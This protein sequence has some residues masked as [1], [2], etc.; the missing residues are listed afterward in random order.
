M[1]TDKLKIIIKE[2]AD[3]TIENKIIWQETSAER[4]YQTLL[5]SGSITIEKVS[6]TISDHIYFSISNVKGRQIENINLSFADEAYDLLEN[7]FSAINRSYLKSDEILDNLFEEIKNPLTINK[8]SDIFIG[9]WSN[10]YTYNNKTGKEIF[11]IRDGNKYIVNEIHYF[12]IED[13][14]WD[15]ANKI[16]KFV[17]VAIRPHDNRRIVN[18]LTQIN[19]KC[20]QGYENNSLPV[21]YTRI[22][23]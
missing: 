11:E 10:V 15:A 4:G 21:L 3:R 9:K 12:N 23:I 20:Y 5:P 1:V 17:K 16:L 2:L 13:F 22:D 14:Y 19:D 7:L 8:L 18:V 6:G